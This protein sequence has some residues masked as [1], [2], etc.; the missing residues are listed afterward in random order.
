MDKKQDVAFSQTHYVEEEKVNRFLEDILPYAN[1]IFRVV[2]EPGKIEVHK[3]A[4]SDGG[5]FID[6]DTGAVATLQI[7]YRIKNRNSK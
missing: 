3:F 4:R 5:F 6:P 1:D 2:L 7:N